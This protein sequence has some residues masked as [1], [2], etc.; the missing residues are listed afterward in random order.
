M[1]LTDSCTG[2]SWIPI[3]ISHPHVK[4]SLLFLGHPVSFQAIDAS[5]G[6]KRRRDWRFSERTQYTDRSGFA[7]CW[8][9]LTQDRG[10]R[11]CVTGNIMLAYVVTE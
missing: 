1:K 6:R 10:C 4:F 3:L 7:N 8:L 11:S 9:I 2:S 5:L